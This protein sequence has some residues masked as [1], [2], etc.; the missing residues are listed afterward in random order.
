MHTA[1]R[2]AFINALVHC[3]YSA[4]GNIVIE[5]RKD[6]LIFSNLRTL[7]I[8]KQ[9]YYQG[10]ASV[11]RNTALQKMFMLI[12]SCGKSGSGVDKILAGWKDAKWG[13]PISKS[14]DHPDRV[15]LTIP[16]VSLLHRKLSMNYKKNII[17]VGLKLQFGTYA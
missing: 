17:N 10:G 16:T 14:T 15:I 9:Q 6:R 1:L 7:L 3:D 4:D 11:C 5:Q 13:N 12:G 8:S 2:E